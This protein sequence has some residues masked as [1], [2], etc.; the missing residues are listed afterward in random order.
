M[1]LA[2]GW[3]CGRPRQIWMAFQ[4]KSNQIQWRADS[5]LLARGGG[6]QRASVALPIRAAGQDNCCTGTSSDIISSQSVS[7]DR[8]KKDDGL[9]S[10]LSWPVSGTRSEDEEKL[11]RE[12]RGRDTYLRER[13]TPPDLLQS[14][15]E[16]LALPGSRTSPAPIVYGC[17]YS[18]IMHE[19]RRAA[20]RQL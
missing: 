18:H 19:I 20:P 9:P 11:K 12:K 1:G 7:K 2:R 13:A 5:L 4:D 16:A 14:P 6:T 8:K 3:P 15:T 17:R 10:K